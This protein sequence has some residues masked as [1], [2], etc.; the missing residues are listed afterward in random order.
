MLS[1]ALGA[2][3]ARIEPTTGRTTGALARG[4]RIEAPTVGG[5]AQRWVIELADEARFTDGAPVRSTDVVA[6]WE[7]RLTHPCSPARWLLGSVVGVDGFLDGSRDR[8]DGLLAEEP[9]RLAI[10]LA[11]DVA[12]LPRRLTHP[13][14]QVFRTSDTSSAGHPSRFESSS[15]SGTFLARSSAEPPF[16]DRLT[17]LGGLDDDPALLLQVG[18]LDAAVIYG[19]GVSAIEPAAG[20][21]EMSRLAGWLQTYAL[22]LGG[23]AWPVRDRRFRRG[24]SAAIDRASLLERVFAGYG[25]T[26]ESLLP[27]QH[28]GLPGV[29]EDLRQYPGARITLWLDAGDP[30]AAVIAARVRADLLLHGVR[31][32]PRPVAGA[33]LRRR[34]DDDPRAVALVV[35]RTTLA[36]PLLDLGETLWR[37]GAGG[38]ESLE[39]LE[40]AS[41]LPDARERLTEAMFVQ[42][43]L[44]GDARL[45]P[46]VHLDAWLVARRGL[47]GLEGGRFGQL[48]VE[49]AG[50][51]P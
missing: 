29:A 7:S 51:R 49:R 9:D 28:D 39:L 43:L 23:D 19:R 8:V 24:L 16:L 26:A 40:R 48:S 21:L 38:R 34:L 31:L 12:D 42:D 47:V 13:A 50:W 17:V 15:A 10:E 4:W 2:G 1:G 37:T 3:L 32:D 5:A 22:W 30:Q 6:W 44:V 46:L 20:E 35:Y 11:R 27:G 18:E 14:L 33:E 41:R 36:E 25:S 45:V